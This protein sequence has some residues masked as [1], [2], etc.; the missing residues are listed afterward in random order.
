ALKGGIG[1]VLTMPNTNPVIDSLDSLEKGLKEIAA[2][3]E[4]TGV[5]VL[6]SA[7]LTR[8]QDGEALVDVEL[9]KNKISAFTDDGKGVESDGLM[10]KG[11][12]AIQDTGIPFLQHAEFSGHKGILAPSQK[13]R[14]IGVPAYPDSAEVDMVARDIDLLRKARGARYHV[15]H[16]SSAKTVE[17]I[18]KAKGEGL[19]VTAEVTPHHLYFTAEDIKPDNTAFKMNPP[20]RTEADR[21]ALIRGLASGV[22][23]Y[24]ATD[25]AP[26][27]KEAKSRGFSSAPFG[28]IGLETALPVL[29]FLYRKGELSKE[30]LVQVFSTKPAE[31][32]SLEKQFG[33]IKV[34]RPFNAC[35]VDIEASETVTEDYFESSSKNSC[36]LGETLPGRVVATF[37]HGRTWR[38]KN[39][40]FFRE[41]G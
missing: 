22:I 29:L 12:Q 24:V 21:Q 5:Q 25:H 20:L 32:L 7:A 35:V 11:L 17:L 30:R 37:V 9:L 36:F 6:W 41:L 8:G 1:A 10:L 34:G 38:R 19:N 18:R 33:R 14:E 3:Q 28:T 39:S 27:E 26:H 31:F 4:E 13:Q 23:D 40:Q 15:L 16:V 2:A